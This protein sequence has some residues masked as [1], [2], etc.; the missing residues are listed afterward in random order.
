MS[1][2]IYFLSE[3]RI[4]DFTPTLGNVD[5]KLISPL[6]PT[7]AA[8]WIEP[9]VGSYFYNHLLTVYN[10]QT[11]NQY[12]V[13]L[14]SLIQQ[15]L[16]WRVAADI[17]ITTSAQLT[18]KGPQTQNGINS[19]AASLTQVGLVAKHYTHKAEFFDSRIESE[20]R[21]NKGNYPEFTSELN[22]NCSIV[23]LAPERSKGFNKDI[24]FF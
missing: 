24:S 7:M 9:R 4:K 3:Q 20:L 14:I 23:D 15:S 18:N 11:A 16:L 17:T 22:N 5:A 8:M 21:L 10:N 6:V 19:D 1:Q 2:L 13:N 12:E